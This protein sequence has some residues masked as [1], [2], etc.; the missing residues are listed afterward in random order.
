MC[1]LNLEF[2]MLKIGGWKAE[3]EGAN[4]K[5]LELEANGR[6]KPN[7]NFS[8]IKFWPTMHSVNKQQQQQQ[9]LR[10]GNQ[11]GAGGGLMTRQQQELQL[12]QQQQQQ[13]RFQQQQFLGDNQPNEFLNSY[14]REA[15]LRENQVQMRRASNARAN[16]RT[17][18]RCQQ[19]Q[20]CN[21]VLT[22]EVDGVFQELPGGYAQDTSLLR[23]LYG[24]STTAAGHGST[25]TPPSGQI[26]P[27]MQHLA[28]LQRELQRE[29]E[30]ERERE[31]ARESREW[32]QMQAMQQQGLTMGSP[33]SR[34]QA[35]AVAA[36]RRAFPN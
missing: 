4:C 36:R 22:L 16:S 24:P 21:E 26:N 11:F 23:D 2:L 9:L 17:L 19:H 32:M 25:S 31:I 6:S 33:T 35:A 1:F 34:M 30:R 8:G 3:T 5:I 10:N 15:Q 20:P 28:H 14:A 29:Q 27:Q 13:Q 7:N 12:M 18:G